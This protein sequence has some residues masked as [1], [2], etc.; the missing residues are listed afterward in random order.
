MGTGEPLAETTQFEDRRQGGDR[1]HRQHLFTDWR[2]G[3]TG[4]RREYR[5]AEDRVNG[6]VDYY[7]LRVVLVVLGVFLLSVADAAFTLTLL[8]LG[9][10]VEANPLMRYLIDMDVRVF[11][12]LKIAITGAGL[13]FIAAYSNLRLFNCFRIKHAGVSLLGIYAILVA[14][15]LVLLSHAV[16]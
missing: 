8:D 11:I 14:Y 13:I 5:R 4:R 10:A 6:H 9:A 12:N 15:E 1:R 3:L 2:Y 7:D 16:V